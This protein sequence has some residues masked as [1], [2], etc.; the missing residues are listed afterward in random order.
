MFKIWLFWHNIQHTSTILHEFC[1]ILDH[2]ENSQ[3]DSKKNKGNRANYMRVLKQN[4]HHSN[5]GGGGG[6]ATSRFVPFCPALRN[7]FERGIFWSGTKRDKPGH[8]Y[9]KKFKHQ[10]YRFIL[11]SLHNKVIK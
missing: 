9:Y 8:S 4:K 7:F 1:F 3:P 2:Q 11:P 10:K 6:G 5:G